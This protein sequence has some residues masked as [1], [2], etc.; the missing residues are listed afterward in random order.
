[1][2]DNSCQN[3]FWGK[4]VEGEIRSGLEGLIKRYADA[5]GWGRFPPPHR[6]AH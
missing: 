5:D 6:Q 1:V 4:M 3:F 2:E